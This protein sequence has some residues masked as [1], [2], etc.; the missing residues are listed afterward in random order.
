MLTS[1]QAGR[2]ARLSNEDPKLVER[3][4]KGD[5]RSTSDD[6]A[7]RLMEQFLIA[8]RLVEAGVRV[9]DARFSRWDYH[10][11]QLQRARRTTCRCSTRASARWSKTCTSAGWTRT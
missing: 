7:P 10:G 1:Q 6:G 4:G 2:G 5:R 11:E 8:R 3:Y 9:R